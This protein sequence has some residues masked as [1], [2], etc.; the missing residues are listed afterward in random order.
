MSLLS[1]IVSLL[2]SILQPA[3]PAY[4]I[5]PCQGRAVVSDGFGI[6]GELTCYEPVRS[7]FEDD[8]THESGCAARFGACVNRV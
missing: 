7:L 3:R 2:I 1:E 8:K 6:R 4:T 5:D